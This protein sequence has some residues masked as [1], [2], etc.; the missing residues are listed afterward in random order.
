MARDCRPDPLDCVAVEGQTRPS[1]LIRDDEDAHPAGHAARPH[2]FAVDVFADVGRV[3]VIS[4]SAKC[5]GDFG[6]GEVWDM[7]YVSAIRT[8]PPLFVGFVVRFVLCAGAIIAFWLI[9]AS[10][11]SADEPITGT[12]VT[13]DVP[14]AVPAATAT[15]AIGSADVPAAV[16]A[17]AATES[18]NTTTTAVDEPAATAT[19]AVGSAGDAVT[20]AVGAANEPIT[21]TAVTADVPAAV[22]AAT[23]TESTNTT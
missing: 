17:A 22:P 2:L 12:A 15:E 6:F 5:R 4:A 23:A 20:D 13:T 3:G 14:A 8:E 19:E 21:G 10:G 16:P 7:T 18:T 1:G 11:A 9:A